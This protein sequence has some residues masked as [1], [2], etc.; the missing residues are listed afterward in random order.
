MA[1][2]KQAVSIQSQSSPTVT[3]GQVAAFD[4]LKSQLGVLYDEI[5]ALSKKAPDGAV[6]KFKLGI[7][8]EKL[9]EINEL[10]GEN[11]RPSKQFTVFDVESL[12]SNSDVVMIL[13]QYRDALE[14]WR[15]AHVHK[16]GLNEW[17]DWKW[18]WNT[19]D[20]TNIDARAPT[21][22]IDKQRD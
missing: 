8:N 22:Y 13:S 5:S 11:F 7:L 1:S 20:G 2:R 4:R 16:A 10:L 17:E 3:T 9:T 21:R 19:D 18:H 15:S 12:P 14:A 6:N